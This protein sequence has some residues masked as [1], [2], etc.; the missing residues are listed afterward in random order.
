VTGRDAVVRSKKVISKPVIS[1]ERA[2]L[3]FFFCQF[4]CPFAVCSLSAS[5]CVYLRL[6]FFWFVSIRGLKPLA[7]ST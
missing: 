5:I 7:K 3:A 2:K 4:V 1:L 6:S